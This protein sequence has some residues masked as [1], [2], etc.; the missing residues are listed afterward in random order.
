MKTLPGKAL[1][2]ERCYRRGL[3]YWDGFETDRGLRS[4]AEGTL[5]PGRALDLGCGTGRNSVY[6]SRLGWDVTGV[7]LVAEAITLARRRARTAGVAAEFVHG[8]V[9]RLR[10]LGFARKFDLLVDFGC[11]HGI[12]LPRRSSYAS[13]VTEAAA[14]GATLWI[15]ARAARATP[16][17]LTEEFPGW[18][19]VSAEEVPREQLRARR[20][21]VPRVQRR[22]H[23]FLTRPETPPA[24]RLRLVRSGR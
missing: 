1:N 2:Y 24:W 16:E 12:P 18:D 10:E 5:P 20:A 6:L 4:L 17:A 21:E 11:W 23:A 3:A 7:D 14:S 22:L 13:E 8:D 9:T 15:W 19:L